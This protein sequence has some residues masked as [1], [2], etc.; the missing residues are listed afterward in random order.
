MFRVA[1]GRVVL[2]AVLALYASGLQPFR[3][4]PV[5]ASAV[6]TPAAAT[7]ALLVDVLLRPHIRGGA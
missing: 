3:L 5:Y 7:A 6:P 2:A 1:G 4:L